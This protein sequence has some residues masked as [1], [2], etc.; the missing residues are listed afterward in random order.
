MNK[1]MNWT[2]WQ[3]YVNVVGSHQETIE[4][5][6][7]VGN[8][9]NS[10][11][12]LSVTS[13]L[14]VLN[15]I[16]KG[17][18]MKPHR[19]CHSSWLAVS[20]FAFISCQ[21][22]NQDANGELDVTAT[23][24]DSVVNLVYV[25]WQTD[26][27]GYSWVDYGTD[28]SMELSTPVSEEESTD[29][30]FVL[31]GLPPMSDVFIQAH[32][33]CE[34]GELTGQT[35]IGTLN[36]PSFLPDVDVTVYDADRVDSTPYILTTLLVV[37]MA[38]AFNRDGDY[39]WYRS[40]DE[41][42]FAFS[43][44][45]GADGSTLIQLVN[46]DPIDAEESLLFEETLDHSSTDT[47]MAGSAHH[48]IAILDDG[49]IAVIGT[50]VRDWT[51]PATHETFQVVGDTIVELTPDGTWSTLFTVW[52][53]TEPES[54]QEW[55]VSFYSEGEDWTHGNAMSYSAERNSYLLSLGNLDTI[56][57]ID[58]ATGAVI[59]SFGAKGE[60]S[61]ASG[62]T[63]FDFQHSPTWT[64]DGHIL[65][66]SRSGDESVAV[67]YELDQQSRQLNEVW[68]YGQG[69]GLY[70]VAMGFVERMD[71]GNTLINFGSAGVIR[72]VTPE[73]EVVWEMQTGVG[74]FFGPVL[75]FDDFYDMH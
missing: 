70:A 54:G 42:H 39:L 47:I 58:R 32:T 12:H 71:N 40:Y 14:A 18:H 30:S 5:H 62:S 35:Q 55:E 60:Y 11:C 31:M 65:L 8:I 21:N 61:I 74:S 3:E 68:T 66:I 38:G 33:Q 4:R 72:E 19:F 6:A 17:S 64:D 57:E 43:L 24:D 59:S 34:S 51:D 73:K 22:S 25:Q 56:L 49:T 27:P 48:D 50:D 26:E 16:S 20:L 13:P 15:P 44:G 23:A 52:D 45:F 69:E 63:V 67:E 2:T 37:N 28:E 10:I 9:G 7:D 53:W 29:H 41:D 75:T 36:V 46:S 1:K